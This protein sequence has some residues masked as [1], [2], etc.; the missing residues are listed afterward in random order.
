[1]IYKYALSSFPHK[2][3]EQFRQTCTWAGGDLKD[4]QQSMF[5][6][7]DIYY[8]MSNFQR[9]YNTFQKIYNI[10]KKKFLPKN[11]YTIYSKNKKKCSHLA[12]SHQLI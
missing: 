1:L 7:N 4:I 12:L 8:S 5:H 11:T 6:S 9:I 2:K 3:V 10:S